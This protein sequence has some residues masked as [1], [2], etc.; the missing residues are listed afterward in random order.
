M[1]LYNQVKR[2]FITLKI[3][4]QIGFIRL[5]NIE[6]HHAIALQIASYIN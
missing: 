3:T 2:N 6:K 4:S 5:K 1:S